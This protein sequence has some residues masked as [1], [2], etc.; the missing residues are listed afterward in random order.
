MCVNY[1]QDYFFI[2]EVLR[3]LGTYQV[4]EACV[5]VCVCVRE[6]ENYSFTIYKVVQIWPGQ[7][8]TG[9]HTNSP[10]HIWTTLYMYHYG[11]G[12]DVLNV[13]EFLKI[14]GFVPILVAGVHVK[15]V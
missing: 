13:Q 9:L 12:A 3:L 8:V 1:T 4:R 2:M 15:F 7:T 14:V 5:C 6:R 11:I 10:G